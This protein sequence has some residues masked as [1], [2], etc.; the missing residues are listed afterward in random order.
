MAIEPKREGSDE[1]PRIGVAP[2]MSLELNDPPIWPTPGLGAGL[3]SAATSIV[4]I[5]TS[6]PPGTYRILVVADPG[7]ALPEGNKNNNVMASTVITVTLSDLVVPSVTAPTAVAAGTS[8][9]VTNT[10]KNQGAGSAAQGPA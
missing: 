6:T 8:F 7:S 2:W 1:M 9:A 4:T 3:S 10:V 5:P